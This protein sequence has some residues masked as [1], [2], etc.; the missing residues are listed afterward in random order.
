MRLANH[1]EIE[2]MQIHDRHLQR[3][4]D[5]V[6]DHPLDGATQSQESI[7]RNSRQRLSRNC[8]DVQATRVIAAASLVRREPARSIQMLSRLPKLMDQDAASNR[9]AGYAALLLENSEDAQRYFDRAVRLD[10]HLPDCWHL[11]G[12]LAEAK[13][14]SVAAEQYYERGVI[15]EESEHESAI[16][17]SNLQ[18]RN[19]NMRDAIHTLRVC[20]FRDQRSPA[21]NAALANLLQRRAKLLGRRRKRRAQQ[22]FRAEALRCLRT[23]NAA[24]PTAKTLIA[25]G[26]LEQQLFDYSAAR[27]SFQKA[28]ERDPDSVVAL[29]LLAS[30]NV[31]CGQIEQASEQ[32]ER[33]IQRNPNL[34]DT[35]FQYTRAKKFQP[36]K[37]TDQYIKV[38]EQLLS[39]ES[40]ATPKRIRLCFSLA[41]VLDDIGRHDQAWEVYDQGNRL[42]QGHSRPLAPNSKSAPI[43][44]IDRDKALKQQTSFFTPEYFAKHQ[45]TGNPST[46]P[47][48]IVGMP[49]SGTTMTEQILSSHPEI[50]GAGELD[51]INQIRHELVAA[52]RNRSSHT[53][54][55]WDIYPEVLGET[56]ADSLR[57]H[58]DDYIRRLEKFADREVRVTDKMPTNFMHLGL[59]GLLFPGATVIHCRRNPLDVFVSCYCQ[60]LNA[61]F[62]DLEQLIDYHR[63]YRGLMRHFDETLPIKIHTVD[64][65]AMVANPESESRAMIEHCGLSWNDSCLQ[66]HS[67]GRAVHTPSKWQVR[68]PMYKSSVE[69]W[70]RFE[71]Q[72]E[73][74]AQR[75]E[76]EMLAES[77]V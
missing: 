57:S 23:A 43:S 67:N 7:V 6:C 5:S 47:I 56:A 17:L 45:Q 70:R 21:L 13:D 26:R 27:E 77:I 32:F 9:L 8:E 71:K 4:F 68:Q 42:K 30:A 49:R 48:F 52:K 41:K 33:V 12:K 54:V 64:Y 53:L 55:N 39:D 10:P 14:D 20:L 18:L 35:H 1:Q 61:P 29:A 3:L 65:E 36:S 69:K 28:V 31:D 76:A 59:I 19:R 60:N 62:C 22:Q 63:T 40:L 15:F 11:L 2:M 72:L 58:A 51:Y 38:L 74:I 66:F 44:A 25:Q 16:S 34:V 75:I 73:P 37:K 24:A 46:L 50:A